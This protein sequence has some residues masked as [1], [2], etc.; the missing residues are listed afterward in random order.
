MQEA[1][2]FLIFV[3]TTLVVVLLSWFA[4]F[5]VVSAKSRIIR[6]QRQ[7]LEAEQQLRRAQE[8]FADNAHH[9]LRTPLQI[10]SGTLYMLRQLGPNPE[11]LEILTR[12]DAASRRL[13]NLVQ[14]LLDFTALQ[15]GMLQ[16]HPNLMDLEAHLKELTAEYS[17]TA[18]AKGLA[19]SVEAA[20]L[21]TPVACDGPRLRRALAALL[22][23]AIR[24]TKEGSIQ[25]RWTTHR[26]DGRCH[27]RFEVM[28]TGAGLPVGW[29]TLLQPFQQG[30]PLPH[31]VREG[32]GIGLPLAAGL[33]NLLGGR[34]GLQP[35][36]T[37]T[38]AWVELQLEEGGA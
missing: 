12:A 2:L 30:E 7:A 32:L 34:M 37:G 9:E 11:Q 5:S 16:V 28:D 36:A 19:L 8:T 26:A 15:Q 6:S 25:V 18:A 29:P 24:F 22:E 35:H 27:L 31:R 10:L 4:L 14:D 17:V 3:L 13:Q 38:L 33:I 21:P 23:N 1:Q 20:P